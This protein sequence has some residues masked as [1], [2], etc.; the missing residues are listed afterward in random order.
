MHSSLQKEKKNDAAGSFLLL[1][2]FQAFFFGDDAQFGIIGLTNKRK[3]IKNSLRLRYYRV[4][5][6]K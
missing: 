1:L 6:A 5:N 4:I 3:E 2:S